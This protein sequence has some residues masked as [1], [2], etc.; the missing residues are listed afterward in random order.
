MKFPIPQASLTK[1]SRMAVGLII[2]L[3]LCAVLGAVL[4]FSQNVHLFAA[5]PSKPDKPS[6]TP[7]EYD[8]FVPRGDIRRFAGETLLINISFLWFDNAATARV[9]FYKEGDTYYSILE[10]E[11]KGFVGFFTSYRY[12]RYK[13]TFDIIDNG[14]RVRTR[15]FEREVIIGDNVEKTTHILDY[16]AQTD[17]WYEFKNGKKTKQD[18]HKIPKGIYF[19]DILATFY[20]FRNSV[21]GEMKRK[22]SY[23]INTIP[24]KGF[25]KIPVYVNSEKEAEEYGKEYGRKKG[26]EMLLKAVIPK[27]IFKTETGELWFWISKHLVPMETTVK[28]YFLLGDLHAVLLKRDYAPPN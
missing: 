8:S 2:V 13:S 1:L 14:R 3:T 11:T 25:D 6:L 9:R 23:I 16:K 15:K 19:D 28:D 27:A 10:S 5:S 4:V 18:Q 22:S 12:H 21:Y 17:W 20:N 7:G 26:Y 24:D